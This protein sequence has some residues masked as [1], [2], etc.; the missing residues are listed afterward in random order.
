[1]EIVETDIDQEFEAGADLLEDT[2][3]D[4]TILGLEFRLEPAEPVVAGADRHF[5]D[6]ADME[7]VDLD[8]ERLGFEAIALARIARV[9]GLEAG[10][11]LAH[12]LGIGLAP[13]PLDIADDAFESLLRLVG[14]KPIVIDESDLVFAGAEEHGIARLLGQI[15]PRRRHR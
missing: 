3:S 13:A 12:P 15:L 4:L 11:L 1:M 6:L 10:Q 7:L 14:A 8:G 5:R 9:V 2:M